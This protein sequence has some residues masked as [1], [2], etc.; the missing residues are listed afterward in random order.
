MKAFLLRIHDNPGWNVVSSTSYS[1]EVW[2]CLQALQEN[3]RIII[4]VI[5]I[6]HEL[7]LDRP[8][9]ATSGLTIS[10]LVTHPRELIIT[11]KSWSVVLN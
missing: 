6:R 3:R 1:S 5:I 9:P 4:I 7:G 2:D 11:F 10:T 8:V